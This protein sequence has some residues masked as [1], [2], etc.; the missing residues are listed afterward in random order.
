[1]RTCTATAF[2]R[3]REYESRL[4]LLPRCCSRHVVTL[5]SPSSVARKS[6]GPDGEALELLAGAGVPRT[7]IRY[8][9]SRSGRGLHTYEL[10]IQVAGVASA[11]TLVDWRSPC[12]LLLRSVTRIMLLPSRRN[13]LPSQARCGLLHSPEPLALWHEE[14]VEEARLDYAVRHP[15]AAPMKV[16]TLLSS[17]ECSMVPLLDS[18]ATSIGRTL[19]SL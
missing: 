18:C 14:G 3:G 17:P 8:V 16:S 9:P 6:D 15:C 13:T 12:D 19:K 10:L 7:A 11:I 5:S 4:A 2:A 1:M